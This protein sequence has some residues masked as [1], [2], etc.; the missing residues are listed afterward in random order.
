MN[1][2]STNPKDP[3]FLLSR[4]LDGDLTDK[5]RRQLDEAL[6]S[7]ESLRAEEAS[8]KKL[9]ALLRRWSSAPVELDW[10]AHA[11]LINGRCEAA[12]T[13]QDESDLDGILE[14]WGR[15]GIDFDEK[16]FA[17]DVMRR[18]G[19][20]RDVGTP[21]RN[22]W[23]FRIGVPLAAAA[24][25]AFA[26]LGGPWMS[27]KPNPQIAEN[28]PTKIAPVGVIPFDAPVCIVQFARAAPSGPVDVLPRGA[29]RTSGISFTAIGIVTGGF[30]TIT[31]DP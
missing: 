20:G 27:G 19:D 1:D 12:D 7:S 5:E 17:T 25:L 2:E 10:E 18:V 16:N 6:K 23:V 3:S 14:R 13:S 15:D 31:S 11:A 26:L 4:R 22:P 28:L 21:S 24:A 8:I 9:N 29:D 30:G